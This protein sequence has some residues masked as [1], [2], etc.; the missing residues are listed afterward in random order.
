MRFSWP[1]RF[2]LWP[3][4]YTSTRAHGALYREELRRRDGLRQEEG[5]SR[6][7]RR[8]P[9]HVSE[10]HSLRRLIAKIWRYGKNCKLLSSIVIIKEKK[11]S[12]F[13]PSVSPE[14]TSLFSPHRSPPGD[15]LFAKSRLTFFAR[16]HDESRPREGHV[17]VDLG[18]GNGKLF[19][20]ELLWRCLQRQ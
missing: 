6:A 13:L 17:Q 12:V 9:H 4:P 14:S 10:G 3:S 18:L 16:H 15:L 11:I 5:E 8:R 7:S 2:T 19:G 1:F 20:G